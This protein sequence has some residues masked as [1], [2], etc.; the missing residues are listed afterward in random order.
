MRNRIINLWLFDTND[1]NSLLFKNV[2]NKRKH[3]GYNIKQLTRYMIRAQQVGG[4]CP[5][6]PEGPGGPKPK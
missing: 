4:Q 2:T 1:L 5:G 6:A 3:E